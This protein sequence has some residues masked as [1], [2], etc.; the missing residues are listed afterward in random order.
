VYV[1]LLVINHFIL[2]KK[3][4]RYYWSWCNNGLKYTNIQWRLL[5][6][7]KWR[8]T[9]KLGTML[10]KISSYNR[11]WFTQKR[12]RHIVFRFNRGLEIAETN[13]YRDPSAAV[14]NG[15]PVATGGKK[16]IILHAVIIMRR[17]QYNNNTDVNPRKRFHFSTCSRT[18]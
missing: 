13:P 6:Q 15:V 5:S 17:R 1:Y 4:S 14:D 18:R 8:D 2:A 10:I 12:E 16:T 11:S 7:T 9:I 3:K